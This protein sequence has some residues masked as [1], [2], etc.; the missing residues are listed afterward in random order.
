[1][2]R[3]PRK[4]FW[5]VTRKTLKH[6]GILG[7]SKNENILGI[8]PIIVSTTYILLTLFLA[9]VLRK[10]VKLIYGDS[11]KFS[12][13]LLLEFIA[14]LELCA[15]C[16]ELIII[17][18]NWGISAYAF[19]LFLLTVWWGS[20]WGSAS[21]CPYSPIEE[22][23]EG[24]QDIKTAFWLIGAQLAGALLTF[25]YV[26]V[27]WSLE[28]VETHL[29]KAYEDCTTDL[30]V[31]TGLGTIIEAGATCLCRIVSR[32]LS[33]SD[34]KL[35]N[36]FDA[37]FGTMMVVA[38]FNFSGGYF[39]PA[40]A[41]S[42]KLGCDGNTFVEHVIVYWFGAIAGAIL[43]IFLYKSVFIQNIIASVKPKTE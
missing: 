20:N 4:S 34:A 38:A 12:K 29:D 7:F 1:M 10:I 43:S 2:V 28:L 9:S 16:Y 3:K 31:D 42:L 23:I 30:Q 21:A 11:E 25:R 24:N 13:Q 19:Y 5:R 32:I 26:Q 18:D 35:G 14:T 39:N 36:Y 8:N 41:T 40:L 27:L 6:L 15:C 33:E 17:A 37:F 22:V